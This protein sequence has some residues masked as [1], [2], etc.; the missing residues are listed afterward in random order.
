[1]HGVQQ[2]L[3]EELPHYRAVSIVVGSALSVAAGA[4]QN[5]RAFQR[6]SIVPRQGQLRFHIESQHRDSLLD[7]CLSH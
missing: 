2:G 4:Q 7:L 1:M 3:I 6:D 5:I